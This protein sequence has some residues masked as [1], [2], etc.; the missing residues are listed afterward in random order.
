MSKK[1]KL[2][3]QRAAESAKKRADQAASLAVAHEGVAKPSIT[4]IILSRVG[5]L[6]EEYERDFSDGSLRIKSP[7]HPTVKLPSLEDK[8]VGMPPC[9]ATCDP[10]EWKRAWENKEYYETKALED[11]CKKPWF[12]Y[13][14]HPYQYSE[15]V[16]CTP[17]MCVELLKFMPINRR[18][19]K[20]WVETIRRDITNERWLQ[21]HESIAINK[22]GNMHDGQHRA[23]GIIEAGRG[24]P[25]YVTWNVPPEA[26]Y[27]T[28]SGEKRKINEKLALLF[29]EFKMS[30][31]TAALCR[32]MMWGLVARGVRYSESELA[33]F[34]AIHQP[35]ISWTSQHLRGYRADMQAVIGKSLLWWGED[36]IWPFVERL[37]S[38]LF[39]GDG[40][41]ARALYVWLQNS[42]NEGRKAAYTN[43]VV[44]YKKTLAAVFAHI[45]SKDVH[46]IYQKHDDVFDWEAG[47]KVPEEAPCHG[48][49]FS[50]ISTD[51]ASGITVEGTE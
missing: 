11:D 28:D 17:D 13:P 4:Q 3:R 26:L 41:P 19:K 12:Q 40:D 16:Y 6:R 49:I 5:K 23:G 15:F 18:M 14:R 51:D 42:K 50:G 30:N 22:L 20:P 24:W 31:K 35:I 32:S 34:A 10:V 29:P 48:H 1:T 38:V 2:R 27:V 45:A 36:L 21:T 37:T 33:E 7:P 44:F 39:T 8:I 46:K 47:W 43:S 25:I 9:P